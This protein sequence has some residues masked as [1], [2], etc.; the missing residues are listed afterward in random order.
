M[1]RYIEKIRTLVARLHL[2]NDNPEAKNDFNLQN[3][4]FD[5]DDRSKWDAAWSIQSHREI[6]SPFRL[7]EILSLSQF[8]S[9]YGQVISAKISEDP[10]E[11]SA[12]CFRKTINCPIC[13]LETIAVERIAASV[14][15]EF[16]NGMNHISFGV[17]VHKSC[18]QAC[19]VLYGP[20]PIPW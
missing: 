5:S 17:W 1:N 18:F 3:S 11:F 12:Q 13:G 7:R 15:P 2:S 10:A 4:K 6:E 19:P 9:E 16:Q 14:H 8:E 20:A